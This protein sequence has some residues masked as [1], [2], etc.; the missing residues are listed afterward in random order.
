MMRG[1]KIETHDMDAPAAVRMTVHGDIDTSTMGRLEDALNGS[2]K[3]G[4]RFILIDM[5]K[6]PYVSS[7]GIGVLIASMQEAE[8][9]GGGI[10]LI[11]MKPVVN[12][13]MLSLGLDSLFVMVESEKEA[14]RRLGMGA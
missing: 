3:G 4:A 10:S 2:L 9:K 13:V 14:R 8:R 12:Q 1:I 5:A 6:V 11:S 7:S